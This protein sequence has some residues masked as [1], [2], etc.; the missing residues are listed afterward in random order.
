MCIRDRCSRIG[1][2]IRLHRLFHFHQFC[3]QPLQPARSTLSL[4]PRQADPISPPACFTPAGL[5]CTV[6]GIALACSVCPIPPGSL[7]RGDVMFRFPRSAVRWV[8]NFLKA[9]DGPTAVEY[10][11]M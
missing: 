5:F 6:G 8:S 1:R 3:A 10:A 2:P 9:E 7:V 11:V 4:P